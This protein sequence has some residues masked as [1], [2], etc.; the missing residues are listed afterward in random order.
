M[1]LEAEPFSA[2]D[3]AELA[4]LFPGYEIYSL[5][6]CGGMGAVYHGR[7]VAL[8]RQVAIKILPREFSNDVSFREGFA[9]EARAMAKLNHPNLIG[10]YDFGEAD[11]MLYI[12]MEY[13]PGQSLYHAAYQVMVEP[14]EAARLMSEICS[15]L[16]EAHR[17][18]ILH[19]DIKPANI[20]LDGHNRPKIGDFGLARPIGSAEK[21]GEV[22]YGTPHYTA[23]EVLTNPRQVDAR[24]DVFSLGVV[25]HELLTGKLPANDPRPPSLISGCSPKFDAIVKRATQP[26]HSLRYPDAAAMEQDLKELAVVPAYAA[27]ARAAGS[28]PPSVRRPRATYTEV[29]KSSGAG[30]LGWLLLLALLGAGGYYYYEKHYKKPAPEHAPAEDAPKI[31]P[32]D[33]ISEAR[34]KKEKEEKPQLPP[35]P[36]TGADDDSGSG[37]SKIFDT[38]TAPPPGTTMVAPAEGPKPIFGV[39]QFLNRARGIMA[40][41]SEVPVRARA[42]ALSSSIDTFEREVSR[43]ARKEG[44][45]AAAS[46]AKAIKGI[47]DNR[48]RIPDIFK[49]DDL[50]DTAY[51][52]AYAAAIKRQEAADEAYHTALKP[53][54][55]VYIHG[56]QMQI[57]R[58]LNSDDPGAMSLLVDEIA[59]TRNDPTHFGTVIEP[60]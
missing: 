21:E 32:K 35:L 13:V 59:H 49:I 44:A 36:G 38:P 34:P 50:P 45:A 3:P 16:A 51:S 41:K 5:I 60:K 57:D 11:G 28:R 22:V 17:H 24:A 30:A 15:G 47:R 27:A 2:P 18:G 12:I 43:A 29:K 20:L 7:Q 19:R 39:E 31:N 53:M 42:S 26:V 1:S 46:A 56:I 58:L 54:A 33:Y 14:K 10:V 25:L 23:P 9:S 52:D 55:D 6:A 40:Q 4:S 37:G 48:N 8:D